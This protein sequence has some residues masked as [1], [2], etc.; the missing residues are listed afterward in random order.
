MD[1]FDPHAQNHSAI[2]PLFGLHRQRRAGELTAKAPAWQATLHAQK[3]SYP[4][5]NVA[6]VRAE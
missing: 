2:F 5:E 3:L 6:A 1:A 4:Q